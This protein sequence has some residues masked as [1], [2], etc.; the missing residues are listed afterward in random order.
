MEETVQKPGE[1]KGP[2]ESQKTNLI[3]LLSYLGILF[4]I[5]LLV[6]KDDE[7]V[8]FHVKQGITLFVGEII[9]G[10]V[11]VVPIIG[12]LFGMVAGIFWL[13]LS[14]MGILNVL[15]GKRQELPLIGKYAEQW[16]V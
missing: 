8:K 15:S 3:A 13:V 7:F 11:S 16:K 12:W 14:V 4:I 2:A 1:V 10:V 9:T 5:P 6:A